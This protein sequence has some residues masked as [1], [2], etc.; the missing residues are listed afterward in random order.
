ME[1]IKFTLAI[2]KR[3]KD[4]KID[5][6]NGVNFDIFG[7]PQEMVPILFDDPVVLA[8]VWK[9]IQ[10]DRRPL[11]E[12]L[13]SLDGQDLSEHACAI[14]DGLPD[15]M[16]LPHLKRVMASLYREKIQRVMAE[17]NDVAR[18]LSGGASGADSQSADTAQTSGN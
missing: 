11:D 2:A 8:Q 17:R 5:I 6:G 12:Y 15:F 16:S 3:I 14:L 7:N 18:I 1:P 13:A 4:A 9:A 10:G